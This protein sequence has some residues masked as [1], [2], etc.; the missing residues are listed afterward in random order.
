MKIRKAIAI[1]GLAGCGVVDM[2]KNGLAY[3]R[4]VEADLAR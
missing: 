4:A 3:S 1:L 2:I